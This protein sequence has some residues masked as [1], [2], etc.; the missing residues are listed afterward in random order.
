VPREAR[1]QA[2]FPTRLGSIRLA[3][4]NLLFPFRNPSLA[5][6]VGVIYWLITWKFMTQVT[7]HEISAG[8]ID[9]LGVYVSLLEVLSRRRD[10]SGPQI[11][12]RR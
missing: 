3:F 12:R 1:A 6:V 2:F 7:R 11:R 4:G 8:K 10:R 5:F 9:G